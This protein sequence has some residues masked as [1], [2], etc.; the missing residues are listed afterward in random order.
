[1]SDTLDVD[2]VRLDKGRVRPVE[3]PVVP[4]RVPRSRSD[5]VGVPCALCDQG[6]IYGPMGVLSSPDWTSPTGVGVSRVPVKNPEGPVYEGNPLPP[7]FTFLLFFSP[8]HHRRG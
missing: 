1:M 6:G 3:T 5:P 7:R 8:P 4:Q 2:E